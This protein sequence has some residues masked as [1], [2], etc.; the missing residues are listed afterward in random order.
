MAERDVWILGAS[1]TKFGRYPDKDLIDLGADAALAALDDAGVTM[2]EMDVMGA[3]NLMEAASGVGQRIQKQVGQNGVPVYN[4]A[5][6]CATGATAIRCVY[7]AIKSGEAET[8]IAVGLEKM[9]KAG[10]LGSAPRSDKNVFEPSG[11]YGSV[12]SVEGR[13]GTTLMPGVFAQAGMEYASEHDGVGFEQFAKV[14]EKNHAHSTL[15][16]LAQYQ[17][18]FS[19]DEVMDAEMMAYPNTLL[20]C[21]PTGDGSAALV[22]VSEEK[23]ATLSDNQRKRAVKISASVMTSDPWTE[24][25]QVQ[26]DV[27]TLTR[28]A[29]N[30]AYETA[31]VDPSDLDLVELHDC[32][33]T[34]E[35]IHY[36]NLGLCKPGEAGKFIDERGP[37]RDGETP[38]NA[39]GGLISKGHPL[40]ATGVANLYEVA[41]HLRGEAGDRQIEDAKVGLTHVIGLG[42]A[43]AVHVLEKATV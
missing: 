29:A 31:G 28:D 35:L 2:A 38:V 15:N 1:M 12:M 41:T 25:D 33:A 4:V 37:W 27:N 16:P 42:S 26:P 30:Q 10:L 14:A 34:A 21:C 11:R 19:L 17:K 39:S 8:G 22:L 24:T 20:M 5:N 32:F 23:L 40:G 7:M 18:Q 6:A 13:V 9:G 43:C 36:D 3:G